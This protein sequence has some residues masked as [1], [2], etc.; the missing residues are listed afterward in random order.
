MGTL[1]GLQIQSQTLFSRARLGDDYIV[2]Q[3]S[4]SRCV[5]LVTNQLN[6]GW[7]PRSTSNLALYSRGYQHTERGRSTS[8][9]VDQLKCECCLLANEQYTPN[10]RRRSTSVPPAISTPFKC[11]R[12][13]LMHAWRDPGHHP[14]REKSDT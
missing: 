8:S 5:S 2:E 9:L 11:P 13:D 6:Q 1:Q 3:I 14:P 7:L 10:T 4:H 12:V